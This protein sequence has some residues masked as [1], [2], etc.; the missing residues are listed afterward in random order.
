MSGGRKKKHCNNFKITSKALLKKSRYDK[1]EEAIGQRVPRDGFRSRK[2][3]SPTRRKA[4][5]FQHELAQDGQVSKIEIF[6]LLFAS[7]AFCI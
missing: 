4:V 6:M 2:T 1:R 5:N 7:C 3:Y